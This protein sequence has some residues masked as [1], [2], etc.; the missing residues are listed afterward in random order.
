M[1]RRK[2][3]FLYLATDGEFFKI[4]ISVDPVQRMAALG[5]SVRLIKSWRRPYARELEDSIKGIFSYARARGTEWFAVP[6]QE[7]MFEVQR[8]VRIYDDERAIQMGLEPS[9]RPGPSEPSFIP[10][11]ELAW[12]ETPAR[13]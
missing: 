4:G 7:M 13:A 9:K 2:P 1:K 12:L 8:A 11:F 10:P 3:K 6:E 5:S